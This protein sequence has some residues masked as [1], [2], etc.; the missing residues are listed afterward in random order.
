[1]ERQR[2]HAGVGR[3]HGRESVGSGL[4]G[5]HGDVWGKGLPRFS[6]TR[7][8]TVH[9]LHETAWRFQTA[10]LPRGPF[11]HPPLAFCIRAR[12]ACPRPHFLLSV[13]RRGRE[14]SGN[15]D[16]CATVAFPP[17]SGGNSLCSARVR[18][19]ALRVWLV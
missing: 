10:V 1:M 6:W 12:A 5:N 15:K 18:A 8:P 14:G 13:K 4:P 17:K 16:A 3:M 19:E 2:E 7:S 11:P 9:T